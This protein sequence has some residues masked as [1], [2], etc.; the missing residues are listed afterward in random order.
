MKRLEYQED[1]VE[2]FTGYLETLVAKRDN[3]EKAAAILRDAGVDAP[4]VD[5]CGQTWDTLKTAGALPKAKDAQGNPFVPPWM[6][7]EDGIGRPMPNVCLKLPTGAGKT[8]LATRGIEQLQRLYYRRAHGLVLWIVPSDAIYTQT[9]KTLA[10]REHPYRMTLERASRGAREATPAR[11]RLH[12][13]GRGKLP[14][15]LRDDDGGGGAAGDGSL[16]D[17]PGHRALSGILPRGR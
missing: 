8:Y 12:Q 7:R 17:V 3:A 13:D 5:W 10:N 1:T 11:R 15:R 14:L 4:N 16:E 2:R 6:H 9:W